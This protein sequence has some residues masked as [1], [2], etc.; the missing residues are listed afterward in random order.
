MFGCVSR[1]PGYSF[2]WR[3]SASW[4]LFSLGIPNHF[5]V[6][7]AV[8]SWFQQAVGR[9]NQIGAAGLSSFFHGAAAKHSRG[10]GDCYLGHKT[11]QTRDGLRLK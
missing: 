8:K 6:R 11:R 4:A 7:W 2:R 1:R 10:D 3:E 5:L 9:I